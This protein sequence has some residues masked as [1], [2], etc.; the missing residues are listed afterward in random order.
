M[1]DRIRNGL[2]WDK[3]WSL[4][5]GCTP[6]SL[7]CE[8]CWAAKGNAMRE[9]HPNS[10]VRARAEGLTENGCF[11][12]QI[13]LNH[14]F[15][16][17]PL[18]TRKPT[19]WAIWNDLFHK[20]VPDEFIARVWW[21]MGQC[22][23]YLD[24][25]RERQHQFLILT[26]RPE[27]MK[28][29]LQGWSNEDT[30]RKW[31]ESMGE[32]FDWMDGPKYWPDILPNV[33]LGVTAENQETADER[34]PILL[35]TPAAVRFISVEPMLSRLDISKYMEV[36]HEAPKSGRCGLRS[37]QDGGTAN[38][39]AGES[40]EGCRQE[41]GQVEKG[42]PLYPMHSKKG[43]KGN[44]EIS[45]GQGNDKQETCE[46]L[47]PQVGV[48][49]FQW[50]NTSGIDDK[51]QKRQP[52]RQQ[53]REPR[54]GDV[55][56]P[57]QTCGQSVRASQEEG[58][59]GKICWVICGGESGHSA[60]PL[61]SEWVKGL[62]DQCQA[63]GTPFFFKQWGE[64]FPRD[65]W[66]HNPELVLPDDEF[67][68]QNGPETYVF[69]DIH[70]CYPAHKVGKKKAGRLLDGQEWLEIPEVEGVK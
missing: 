42:N 36:C 50:P 47:S 18:Q 49:A 70:D 69:K 46:C 54:V 52:E 58:L 10:K 67:A 22:A 27:R 68:Y 37:C 24:P 39:Q 59:A 35:Q 21:V 45:S 9:N 44:G 31:I 60:R 25:S 51:P 65:Q 43:R 41:V 1:F 38:R 15:M 11:N 61:N 53:A 14:E 33:W 57:N 17:K 16:D 5:S 34:I 23:G 66:E 63:A 13:K 28:A 2:W 56:R 19:A 20:D 26:K 48:E 32:V 64:Y 30:R 62:R 12:G 3:A 55:F 29:W 8:N 6:V 7:A 40:L 4:V